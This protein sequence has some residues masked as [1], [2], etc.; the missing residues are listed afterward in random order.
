MYVSDHT[1]DTPLDP[2]HRRAALGAVLA[3]FVLLGSL[4]QVF[5]GGEGVQPVERAAHQAIGGALRVMAPDLHV[6]VQ[7]PNLA[8]ERAIDRV[9]G[10]APYVS[11]G[12]RRHKEVALTF[13]DGPGPYTQ[14][15]VRVL[16]R[17]HVRATFFQVG[18]MMSTFPAQARAVRHSFPVGDHTLS[19]PAMGQLSRSDQRSQV[20][21][22]AARM[23]VYGARFPRL[24]RPPYASFDAA[25]LAVLRRY[26]LLMVLWSVDSEDYTRPGTKWIVHNVVTRV[27]PGGIVLMHDGGGPREQTVRA[28]PAIVRRLRARGY[29][30]VTVPQMMVDAPP[31]RRQKLPKGA[32]G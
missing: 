15:L 21:D 31:P 1:A 9:L 26:R 14:R 23:R 10:Y 11:S 6:R 18:Q 17:M 13:D 8:Q 28:V 22:Q 2:A 32:P 16:R 4:V 25:T 7:R 27:E 20:L 12:G 5:G 29:R 3:A 24:F 30:F 19:H